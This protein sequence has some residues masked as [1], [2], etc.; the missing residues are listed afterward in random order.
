MFNT[1]ASY[2]LGNSNNTNSDQNNKSEKQ[3]ILEELNNLTTH[4]CDED[5]DWL[6]V[7]EKSEEEDSLPRTDSEEE[8]P[9]YNK[10]KSKS[11]RNRNLSNEHQYQNVA[12]YCPPA[13]SS[14]EESWFVTPPPCFTSTGPINVETSP[15]ENLLIEHPSMSVY[16][17][18]RTSTQEIDDDIVVLDFIDAVAATPVLDRSPTHVARGAGVRRAERS[19]RPRTQLNPHV[20]DEQTKQIVLARNGQK[21]SENISRQSFCRGALERANKIR[22]LNSKGGKQKRSNMYSSRLSSRSNNNRKC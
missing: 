16:R 7:V 21:V 13:T 4:S 8:F 18:M 6:L 9:I 17:F 14:M 12:L 3:E 2:L 1:L 22:E 19:A 11:E 5:D 20:T 15:L 10:K